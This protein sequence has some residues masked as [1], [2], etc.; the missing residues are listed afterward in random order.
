[1][2]SYP[3]L[4]YF[5]G[6][7]VLPGRLVLIHPLLTILSPPWPFHPFHQSVWEGKGQPTWFCPA[8]A[9]HEEQDV[10]YLLSLSL[11][12]KVLFPAE[13]WSVRLSFSG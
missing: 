8:P 3:P 6:R 9:R 12:Q 5:S 4:R 2:S 13:K 11:I 7:K 1:M 10:E